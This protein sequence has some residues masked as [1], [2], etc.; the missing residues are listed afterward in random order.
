MGHTLA[1]N[2]IMKCD[3]DI[4]KDL[5]GS[6]VLSGGSSMFPG[7]ETRLHKEM[8]ALAGPTEI[9]VGGYMRKHS[10]NVQNDLKNTIQ[11]FSTDK[12]SIIA[13]AER[14]HSVWIGGSMLCSLSSFESMW[15]TLG[16][17]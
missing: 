13:P 3:A 9:L 17:Y 16:E 6:I 14:K 10:G 12:V 11:S 5:F 4:R 2:A 15:I 7:I 1:Y 8:I